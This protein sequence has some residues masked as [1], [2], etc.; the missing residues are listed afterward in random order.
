MIQT[1]IA[2]AVVGE[3]LTRDLARASMEQILAGEASA[4]QIGALAVAMRMKGETPAEISG[5]AEAMRRRVPPIRTR[6]SPLLDTCGTGGDNAGTFNI[7]TTVAIVVAACGVPVA[8]HGNRAM[9]GRTG[10][11]DVLEQLGVRIDLTP[12]SAG[13]SLDLLGITFL[14]APNY[15]TA[16]R[17]AAGP[18]REI[19]VRTVFN[20][21]GPLTNPAGATLQLLG[22]YSDQLV[23]PVAE[24][25][26][27]LGSERAWV[28]HGRD[29]LDELTL[30]DKNHVAELKDGKIREFEL[31]PAE[32]GLAARDRS[33]VAGG[34]AAANAAKIR[35][36]LAGQPGPARDIVLLNTAAALCVAGMAADVGEGVQRARDAIDSGAAAAKL[37]ELA[38]FRG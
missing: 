2:R 6:R 20:A 16:L 5:M 12:E 38:A 18:R 13:R 9:S 23:R 28:V 1:A 30:F 8:K 24:V 27:Q 15:H 36:I 29:G 35:G 33:D 37:G 17:H 11:A 26:H 25:L 7:S 4:A 21:L 31:D 14:F 22:V 10:G 19:G 34:D 3:E 32:F